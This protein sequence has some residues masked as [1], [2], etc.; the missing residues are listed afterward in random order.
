MLADQGLQHVDENL[1]QL[2]AEQFAR[3]IILK[4]KRIVVLSI[5]RSRDS[6]VE[7]LPIVDRL[8]R[9]I[10]GI[11]RTRRSHSHRLSLDAHP[12]N[13]CHHWRHVYWPKS[14]IAVLDQQGANCSL[15]SWSL[16]VYPWERSRSLDRRRTFWI[17]TLAGRERKTNESMPAWGNSAARRCRAS[18]GNTDP[19][20]PTERVISQRMMNCSTDLIDGTRNETGEFLL[21]LVAEDHRK[22]GADTRCGLNSR[23]GDLSDTISVTE[24]E[25]AWK[26][27][28]RRARRTKFALTSHLIEGNTLLNAT[29]VSIEVRTL[30]TR[31]SSI[32]WTVRERARDESRLRH[33]IEIGENEGFRW[34]K[35][36]GDDI[37]GIFISISIGIL[38]FDIF[39]E[40]LL[41]I[42][43]LNHQRN[44][45]GILQPS[46]K[47]RKDMGNDFSLSFTMK[48]SYLV[49]MNGTKCP[50][51]IDSDDGPRPVYKKKGFFCS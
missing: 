15:S 4:E 32:R 40:K 44:V 11:G 3:W 6:L 47:E 30:P 20:R 2:P 49:I 24:T 38:K 1:L 25:D 37:L 34:I 26:K 9:R 46:T 21:E 31:R 5:V 8:P 42:G 39:P 22:R 51:C 43:H 36:A 19:I 45:E 12:T 18:S 10:E 14:F 50:R 27:T 7:S 33:V 23:K 13:L 29:D 16:S 28:L 35:S 17:V 48:I 41:V